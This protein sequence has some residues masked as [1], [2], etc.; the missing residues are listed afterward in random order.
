M[1]ADK[2]RSCAA[3]QN[4]KWESDRT[5]AKF[6]SP[7]HKIFD[8]TNILRHVVD[9]FHSAIPL[10]GIEIHSSDHLKAEFLRI[11]P[12][13]ED[14]VGIPRPKEAAFYK[15]EIAGL[16]L[17]HDLSQKLFQID[18]IVKLAITLAIE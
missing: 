18:M 11:F 16:W 5:A 4:C 14:R 3:H 2:S 1:E 10:I 8:P 7:D 13:A 15:T 6:S 9:S 17:T 12:L